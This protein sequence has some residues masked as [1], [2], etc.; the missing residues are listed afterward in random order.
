MKSRLWIYTAGWLRG[1][2]SVGAMQTTFMKGR[3]KG[4][5]SLPELEDELVVALVG[6]PA[7]DSDAPAVDDDLVE[8][9]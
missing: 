3:K 4:K 7:G 2:K 1:L 5:K 9:D 6:L 8:G